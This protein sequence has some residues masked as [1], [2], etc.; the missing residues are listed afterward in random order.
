MSKKI[1]HPEFSLYDALKDIDSV[2]FSTNK[3]EDARMKNYY[4]VLIKEGSS[5]DRLYAYLKNN[6][7]RLRKESKMIYEGILIKEPGKKA[8]SVGHQLVRLNP[9]DPNDHRLI[10][11]KVKGNVK[12]ITLQ[13]Y[14][15]Y[16]RSDDRLG[17][18]YAQQARDFNMKYYYGFDV[19][20]YLDAK[21]VYNNITQYDISEG[22][23]LENGKKVYFDE[24]TDDDLK[25]AGVAY[26]KIRK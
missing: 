20:E 13:Q 23:Y 8:I 19:W 14:G 18:S 12:N 2:K 6:A 7:K 25:L 15:N 22:W 4:N 21:G 11:K 10:S 1:Q 26:S 3:M 9:D 17:L 24:V 16:Y 5:Y